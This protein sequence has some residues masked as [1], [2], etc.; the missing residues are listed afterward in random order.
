MTHFPPP[1]PPGVAPTYAPTPT[2]PTTSLNVLFV[3]D[4]PCIRQLMR[5]LLRDVGLRAETAADGFEALA[6]FKSGDWHIVFTDYAMPGMNGEELAQEIKKVDPELPIIMVTGC[7]DVAL[8]AGVIDAVFQK[9][10]TR[11]KICGAI[12]HTLLKKTEEAA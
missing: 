3:D 2:S 1:L 6:K 11:D 12:W 5:E 4:E 9:P 8:E 10:F 7:G